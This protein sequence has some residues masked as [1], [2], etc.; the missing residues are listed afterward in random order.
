MSRSSA[1]SG[2]HAVTDLYDTERGF[3][4]IRYPLG[5]VLGLG[6][7]G[8]VAFAMA[9][10]LGY[11]HTSVFA[12]PWPLYLW[13]CALIITLLV[14]IFRHPS[15]RLQLIIT[16]I[17]AALCIVVAY[18]IG[19]PTGFISR[20]LK[21]YLPLL[22]KE[23]LTY[24]VVN[25][26]ILVIFWVDT[27]RRWIRRARGLGLHPG[28][29]LTTGAK[30]DRPVDPADEPSMAELIAGDLIAGSVLAAALSY[31]FLP[32]VLNRL[33][34]TTPPLTTCSLAVSF[35]PSDCLSHGIQFVTL[36]LIDKTQA[37]IYLPLGLL[38]LGLASTLGG[39]GAV[40]GAPLPVGVARAVNAVR[41]EEPP[42]AAP[43]TTGVA[44][45]VLDTMRAAINRRLRAV[46]SGL[47]R[48]LRNIVWPALLFVATFGVYQLSVL[49]QHYLHGPK[50]L[51]EALAYVLPAL[52]W[53]V[54]SVLALVFSVALT[55]FSWHVADN[56]LRF[57]GLIGFIVLLT[58]WLFS[59][60][61]FAFNKLLEQFNANVV[62][63]FDPPSTATIVSAAAL[64]IFGSYVLL[65]EGGRSLFARRPAASRPTTNARMRAVSEADAVATR[66]R[67]DTS[68]GQPS[69]SQE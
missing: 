15:L 21:H 66:A 56:T 9:G 36:N 63:P 59:L 4:V 50:T 57:L 26:A 33:I 68:A 42:V 38:I 64:I 2:V 48:S 7:S 14:S 16:L 47:A 61:L 10:F 45:T 32:G 52:G 53:G 60:A 55:L 23:Q 30:V 44:E 8:V 65:T 37:L 58:F 54:V 34:T 13:F 27:L 3:F 1:L 62:R 51:H 31:L 69:N 17:V 12:K 46:G 24:V 6:I 11:S 41:E 19:N 18:L 20:F 35:P 49:I 22:A 29:D 28:V 43:I 67:T 5:L 25:F 40:G 39:F